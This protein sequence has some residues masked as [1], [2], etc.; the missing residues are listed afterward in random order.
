MTAATMVV[1]TAQAS[2]PRSTPFLITG[3]S[4]LLLTRAVWGFSVIAAL[5]P[6]SARSRCPDPCWSPTHLRTAFG[7]TGNHGRSGADPACC[8]PHRPR[9]HRGGSGPGC[10]AALHLALGDRLPHPK[11][12]PSRR[13]GN[14]GCGDADD[15]KA[16]SGHAQ[17]QSQAEESRVQEGTPATRYSG[18]M[19]PHI[20]STP[21]ITNT[22]PS[23]L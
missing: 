2:I 7:L 20:T 12:A 22:T 18:A 23:M 1:P 17:P 10:F 8:W 14:R 4:L 19:I 15:I 13:V 21:M 3:Q 5:P 9:Q 6:R 11:P 16:R